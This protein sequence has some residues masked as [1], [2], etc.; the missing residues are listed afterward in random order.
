MKQSIN[1]LS[2]KFLVTLTVMLAG[3]EVLA[4][5]AQVI[6]DQVMS[7]KIAVTAEAHQ[8]TQAKTANAT[9]IENKRLN[10]TKGSLKNPNAM[11]V[12]MAFKFK[13]IEGAPNTYT[14]VVANYCKQAKY[15][16][17][18]SQFA[19]GWMYA[20]GK[21]VAADEKVAAQLFTMAAEQGH[22]SAQESLAK[23]SNVSPSTALLACLQPDPPPTLAGNIDNADNEKKE[24]SEKTAALFYSQRHILKIVNKLAPRYEIDANLAM[25]FIAVES[26][27][28]VHATSPKNAQGL[29]Q[30]IPETAQRFGVKDPYKAEDNIKGG[31]A[32]LQ[33]LL[34]Y[35]KGDLKLVAAAYNAGEGAVEKYKGVPPYAETQMYVKKVAKLYN[36]TSHPYKD[37]LLKK[38][39][40][41]I[42][43]EN[44]QKNK[45]M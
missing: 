38:T 25:T 21:G 11:L 41:I 16:D 17:A 30:L 6:S 36:N 23:L 33:W 7:D 3:A 39:S 24:I 2:L 15:G 27:F 22:S 8:N 5:E 9:N 12:A 40:S 19:L 18:D 13:N 28:N 35:F 31:L 14:E 4:D 43:L 45:T 44:M 37:N 29:M 10:T 20:N 34:A 1:L 32:Y 26:G 42:S